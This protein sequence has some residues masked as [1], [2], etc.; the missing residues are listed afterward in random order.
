METDSENPKLTFPEPPASPFVDPTLATDLAFSNMADAYAHTQEVKQDIKKHK[1]NHQHDLSDKTEQEIDEIYDKYI[2]N[3][4]GQLKCLKTKKCT[5]YEDI[6]ILYQVFHD[7]L[8]GY[9]TYQKDCR[10]TAALEATEAVSA[11]PAD[12]TDGGD[13]SDDDSSDY[14]FED[15]E[16]YIQEDMEDGKKLNIPM[17]MLRFF[18]YVIKKIMSA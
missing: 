17:T 11:T 18:T 13:D 7:S 15:Y 3:L 5:N 16:K 4:I 9:E 8:K 10:E 12:S 1:K 2:D 14:I 6:C